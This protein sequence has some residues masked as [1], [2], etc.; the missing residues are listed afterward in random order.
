MFKN[1]TRQI[2]QRTKRDVSD[3]YPDYKK[4]FLN[5]MLYLLGKSIILDQ[6]SMYYF[7]A[8]KAIWNF[9]MAMVKEG[10]M[11]A[12]TGNTLFSPVSILTTINMLF[13]GTTGETREEVLKALG[14]TYKNSFI[15][16]EN[17]EQKQ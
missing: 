8:S 7:S 15:T 4:Y 5:L 14:Q 6:Y 1:F 11:E 3:P 17:Y 13:L 10:L 2:H 16:A 9:T 12:S